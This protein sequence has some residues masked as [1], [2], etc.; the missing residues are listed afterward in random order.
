MYSGSAR[1]LSGSAVSMATH[2]PVRGKAG[3]FS[4]GSEFT[5]P[6]NYS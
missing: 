1:V 5:D 2:R 3:A 4:S 6:N